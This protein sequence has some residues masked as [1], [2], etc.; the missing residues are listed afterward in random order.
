[1]LELAASLGPVIGISCP[2][3][4]SAPC[5]TVPG[6]CVPLS[7]VSIKDLTSPHFIG[8]E[9]E[10]RDWTEAPSRTSRVHFPALPH[11]RLTVP[12][13]AHVSYRWGPSGSFSSEAQRGQRSCS[14]SH[15]KSMTQ[16]DHI[17]QNSPGVGGNMCAW[18]KVLRG[19]R[20]EGGGRA[21]FASS[22]LCSLPCSI[23]SL[24]QI[25]LEND[26]Q[27][28]SKILMDGKEVQENLFRV[29]RRG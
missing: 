28:C 26:S 27:E 3:C 5:P 15:S 29:G 13:E 24:P 2:A 1:M 6:T 20:R 8:K 7:P 4:A 12:S 25:C 18:E 11:L 9:T 23:L 22:L 16:A 17:R 21:R 14:R 10:T 19:S